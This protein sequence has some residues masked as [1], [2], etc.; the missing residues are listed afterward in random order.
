MVNEG[1][2]DSDG[3]L[4]KAFVWNAWFTTGIDMHEK[5]KYTR[6]ELL[7][8]VSRSVHNYGVANTCTTDIPVQPNCSKSCH[9][10]NTEQSV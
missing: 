10:C 3:A 5:C 8:D 1:L 7:N 6:A 2:N 4:L 9:T